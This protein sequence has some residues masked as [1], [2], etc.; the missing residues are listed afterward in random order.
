[1]S[2]VVKADC[3]AMRIGNSEPRIDAI[4]KAQG[5]TNYASD[6]YS[7]DMLWAGLK[8]AGVAHG[9]LKSIR[10]ENAKK[11]DGVVA[12]L[13][14]EDIPG[15]KIHGLIRQDRPV[16]IFDKIRFDGDPVALVVARTQ[17][18]LHEALENISID[19]EEL[20]SITD[21]MAALE[22]HSN[23]I[24]EENAGGN[25]LLKGDLY[26]GRP[27]D[28]AKECDVIVKGTFQ[29]PVQEHAY[30]ETEAGWAQL[31]DD[32]KLLVCCSTQT[33]FRDC[34]E[35]GQILQMDPS[36]IRII[37]PYCGG[38]FG[39]KDSLSVQAFLGLAALSSDGRPVKMVWD[40]DES[41][42][43]TSKRHQ[44]KML[45]RLGAK[46]DGI[47]HYLDAEIYLDTGPY[48]YLGGVVLTLALEHAGGVYRIPNCRARGWLLYTNNPI[49]GAF[50]GF[51]VPQVA[52]AMEQMVDMIAEKLGICP[53]ELRLKN[54]IKQGDQTFLGK[55]MACSTGIVQCLEAL[56]G[57]EL[58]QNRD[59]WKSQAGEN[60]R[61]GYGISALIH[62]MGYGPVV[63]DYANA[64]IEL[65]KSG[66][67][68]VYSGVVDMGQGNSSTY[69]QMVGHLLNQSPEFIELVQPD[70]FVTL[71]CCSSSAS[72]TTFTF[73]MALIGAV[74]KIKKNILSYARTSL[75]T[76]GPCAISFAPGLLV[77]QDNKSIS[78]KELAEMM[79]EE[80]RTCS[81]YFEAPVSTEVITQDEN[82]RIHG[83]P[84]Q[85]FSFAAHLVFVEVDTTT[86]VLVIQRYLAVSDCGSVLNPQ[87]YEQQVQGAIA[88]GI[89]YALMENFAPDKNGNNP[90]SFSE[91]LIPTSYD[92]PKIDCV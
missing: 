80:D 70:T 1:M 24:H 82:L 44:A 17:E 34:Y 25:L 23:L 59:K 21:A 33:P 29:T 12:V 60:K 83:L 86:G 51:G 91:Y 37:A 35:V 6:F 3:L 81:N 39:G 57:H 10:I 92:V 68:R 50:R 48:D 54:A 38:A 4:D 8:R 84:H 9:R 53:L 19:F 63:K 31:Q 13:T 72:R 55:K 46:S 14:H 71:P 74:E 40:R 36:D 5:K 66:K 43:A 69:G 16:L 26:F 89:G 90:K 61:R 28:A 67:I 75:E 87:I 77:S 62:G 79:N 85:I 64:K 15:Q 88:Q 20:P 47:L 22:D 32:G 11:I 78:L 30:L 42:K 73:G 76:E 18:I 65:T 58:W 56:S 27:D 45:Y 52:A 7:P 41:F 49:G 2:K